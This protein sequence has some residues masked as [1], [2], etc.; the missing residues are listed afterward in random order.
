MHITHGTV[1]KAAAEPCIHQVDSGGNKIHGIMQSRV[2]GIGQCK[3]TTPYT[4][5]ENRVVEYPNVTTLFHDT[6]LQI[7]MEQTCP[8]W[9][10]YDRILFL[11]KICYIYHNIHDC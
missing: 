2:E 6:H 1:V 5:C 7:T 9:S 10:V 8:S 11:K 3:T 4:P